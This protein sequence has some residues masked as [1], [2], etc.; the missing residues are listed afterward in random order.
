MKKAERIKLGSVQETL[1]L[2]LWGRAVETRKKKP[3]LVDEKA[4]S[5]IDTL[6]YDF[7]LISKNISGI[8]RLSWIARSL[9]FDKKITAFI[10]NYPCAT[11]INVGC[12]LDTTFERVDNGRIQWYDLD[13]PEVIEL[14]RKYITESDRRR[15]IAGS[16]LEKDWYSQIENK[17]HIMLMI[18]GVIYYFDETKVKSLFDDFHS[19]LP[20]CEIIFDYSSVI[21]VHIANKKVIEQGG[22]DTSAYLTW[23]IN[24]IMKIEEWNDAIKVISN[25]P[26]YRDIK[27]EFPLLKR[28]GIGLVDK[29][30][31][32]SLAHIKIM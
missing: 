16:V 13:L 19:C 11:I 30:G 24:D 15:F 3:L 14:R 20:G 29:I 27:K 18:A 21:G 28:I 17:E 4:V 8:S 10:E 9:F 7:N 2:P 23:G 12:G 25:V 22:M 6:P 32:M 5:I 1:L 31:I 26:I